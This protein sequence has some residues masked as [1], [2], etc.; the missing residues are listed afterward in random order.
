M[1]SALSY[2]KK[3]LFSNREILNQIGKE[4]QVLKDK[5][6]WLVDEDTIAFNQV[7]KANRL[8]S[9]SKEEKLKFDQKKF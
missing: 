3:E 4:A 7:I 9:L 8:P 2:E 1:V 5:L 6:S